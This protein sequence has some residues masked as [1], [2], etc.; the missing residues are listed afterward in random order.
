MNHKRLK[1][2]DSKTE[3]ILFGHHSQLKK[4]KTSSIQINN[5]TI[6]KVDGIRYLGAWLA[7]NLS[8]R[9]H[10]AKKCRGVMWNFLRIQL[11]S[12]HLTKEACE[13][14]VI[15]TVLSHLDYGTSLLIDVPT[16]TIKPMQRV[17]NTCAKL[18][19]G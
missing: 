16:S 3:F 6:P 10:V 2:N 9:H 14:L 12:P 18:V 1:M 15:G 13:T 17:Q 4:C 19:F 11:I 7:N 8:F 5:V